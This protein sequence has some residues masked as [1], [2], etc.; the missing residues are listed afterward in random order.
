MPAGE[1][2]GRSAVVGAQDFPHGFEVSLAEAQDVLPG[3]GY[4]QPTRNLWIF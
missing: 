2:F 1:R 3:T 4:D